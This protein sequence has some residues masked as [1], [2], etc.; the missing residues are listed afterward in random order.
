MTTP[1]YEMYLKIVNKWP[2]HLRHLNNVVGNCDINIILRLVL[3]KQIKLPDVKIKNQFS[4]TFKVCNFFFIIFFK[5][6]VKNHL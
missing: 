2:G 6:L 1:K 4:H 5:K 3:F